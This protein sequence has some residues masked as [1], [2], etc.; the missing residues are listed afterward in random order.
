RD[1]EHTENGFQQWIRDNWSDACT[2]AISVSKSYQDTGLIGVGE[3]GLKDLLTFI[4][5]DLVAGS[6][7]ALIVTLGRELESLTGVAVGG[8]GV[9][10]GVLVA[11]GAAFLLGPSMIFPAIVAGVAVGAVTDALIKFRRMADAE[12]A[13]AD[14][15]FAGQIP[16]GLVWLTNLSASNG[17]KFTWPSVDNSILVNLGDAYDDP[18][19]YADP[20]SGYQQPGEV[21]IH[22]LTHAW[23]IAHTSFSPGLACERIIDPSYAFGPPGPPFSSFTIEGQ[24]QIVD[25]WYGG[26]RREADGH[27]HGTGK[28]MD[29][30][31][32]YFGYIENNIRIG[33]G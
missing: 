20:N 25:Y 8:P 4:G 3:E 16:Y 14:K 13:E 29:P 22:E 1:D 17:R 7:I 24:A 19:Q 11:S 12:R 9:L 15:V 30:N 21:F 28:P 31:D 32:P 5:V 6:E 10:P 27:P 18:S 23:Q 26:D 2:A 33:V